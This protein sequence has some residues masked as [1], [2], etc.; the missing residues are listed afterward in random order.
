MWRTNDLYK[1]IE[2]VL[3][4]YTKN[5]GT[6][7][8]QGYNDLLAP[9]LWTAVQSEQTH[10]LSAAE[11]CLGLFVKQHMPNMF[12]DDDFMCMQSCFCLMKL[13]LKY[14]DPEVYTLL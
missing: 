1:S 8:K 14:H 4:V 7:Y 5:S 3:T 6:V 13:L 12:V 2:K 9:F 11:A 10:P